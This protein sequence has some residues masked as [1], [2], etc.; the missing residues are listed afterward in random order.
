[1]ID[2]QLQ[3]TEQHLN[4]WITVKLV[5]RLLQDIPLFLVINNIY[6][7]WTLKVLSG[8]LLTLRK[9]QFSSNRPPKIRWPPILIWFRVCFNSEELSHLLTLTSNKNKSRIKPYNI[10][11]C[12]TTPKIGNLTRISHFPI[13]S[14]KFFKAKIRNSH[15]IGVKFKV[16][17][18]LY[19]H[20]KYIKSL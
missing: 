4:R 14:Y 16:R 7:E 12:K 6:I 10:L 13:C 2:P 15:C 5:L 8:A 17:S 1:M 18:Q 3:A 9:C 20:Q 19:N 11:P